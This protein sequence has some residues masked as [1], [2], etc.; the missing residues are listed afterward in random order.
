MNRFPRSI[1]GDDL[2]ADA[3]YFVDGE[4]DVEYSD[5][6]LGLTIDT[7]KSDLGFDLYNN[8][9]VR[10]PVIYFDLSVF[11]RQYV[12]IFCEPHTKK[13][14]LIKLCQF[15]LLVS[16][17]ISHAKFFRLEFFFESKWRQTFQTR[18]FHSVKEVII[19]D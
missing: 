3:D 9:L 13:M 18:V 8:F 11:T 15:C 16:L 17:I 12:C 10:A 5:D 6:R 2:A 19:S 14:S 4:S 7:K 1:L